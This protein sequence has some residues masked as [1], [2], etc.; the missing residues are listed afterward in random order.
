ME[1]DEND[2]DKTAFSVGNGL[3]QFLVIPSGLCNVPATF[4]RLMEHYCYERRLERP[5]EDLMRSVGTNSR[6]RAHTKCKEVFAV[7]CYWIGCRQS[8]VDWIG[9]YVQCI[10]TRGPQT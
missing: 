10:S 3:W 9:T 8:V 5:S 1:T 7:P 2:R 4:E 6:C